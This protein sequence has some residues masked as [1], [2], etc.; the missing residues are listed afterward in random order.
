MQLDRKTIRRRRNLFLSLFGIALAAGALAY[1]AKWRAYDRFWVTTDN[2]FVT[3]N[4]H[5]CRR[6]GDGHSS[7]LRGNRT[8]E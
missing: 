8:C 5:L 1:V 2:A 7:L 6:N 3:G 4:P